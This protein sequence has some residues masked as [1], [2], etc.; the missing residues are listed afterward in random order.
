MLLKGKLTAESPIYRGNA[1]KTLF[2]RDGDGSQRMVSLSGEISGTA[3]ALM[4][5]F[6]GKSRNGKNIGLINSL[7]QRLYRS[8]M[9]DNLIRR[10]DCK[11]DKTSY[12]KD[13]F[14]D[15]RMGI[16]LDEERASAEANANY[17]METIFRHAVFDFSMDVNDSM[18]RKGELLP[19]LY[20]V[21]EELKSGRFWFGAGKS[22]GL[23]RCLLRLSNDLP[24]PLK[25]PK[26]DSQA[27]HMTI[28]IDINASNP[29]LIGWNWGKIDPNI[30]AFAAIEGK[31]LIEGLREIPE[32]IS[33]R[34][35]ISIGGPISSPDDWKEKFKQF[36]PKAIVAWLTDQGAKEKTFWIFPQANIAK[37]SKGKYP[38][39]KKL[40]N[41]VKKLG[42]IQ[43]SSKEDAEKA[44]ENA[45]GKD[46]KKAKRAL[47][48]LEKCSASTQDLDIDTWKQ[49][50]DPL[51][52]DENLVS[53]IAPLIKDDVALL[54]QLEKYLKVIFPQLFQKIDRQVKLIQSDAWVDME[55]STR[56]EHIMIKQMIGEGKI[57]EW[58][59]GDANTPP[60]GIK[61]VTWKE[62]MVSHSRV[63]YKHMTNRSNLAKSIQN[64]KNVI[65]FLNSYRNRTRQELSQSNLTDFRGGGPSGRFISQQFGKPYDTVF[66][67]M[68]TWKPSE[69]KEGWEV[70]I[71][72]STIK[73]AFRKRA[74]QILKTIWGDNSPKT[75]YV[76]ERIFG[77]QSKQGLI[78][79]SDAYLTDPNIPDKVW[80]SMDGVRMNPTTG[81]PVEEAKCD[82]LFAYGHQLLFNLR[83]D[84]MDIV[85]KDQEVLSILTYLLRDFQEGEI[86]IGGEKTNGFGWVNANVNTVQ[87][88]AA[89]SPQVVDKWLNLILPKELETDGPW[90][91]AVIKQDKLADA[92]TP[93]MPLQS[94][95]KTT[96]PP[97]AKEGFISHRSF[98]GHCGIL[99]FE[100]TALTPIAIKESGEPSFSQ[101]MDGEPV[102]GWDFFNMAS[103]SNNS[104]ESSKKYAIPSKTLK[105]MIRHIYT[106]ASDSVGTSP[107]IGSLNDVDSLF[108]WVGHGPNQALMGRVSFDFAFFKNPDLS[109]YKV[110]YPYGRW[111]YDNQKWKE[112][113]SKKTITPVKIKNWRIFTHA[114]IAPCVSQTDE[115]NP[116]TVQASYNRA[117]QAGSTCTFGVRFWNLETE[118]LQRLLWCFVLEKGLAH[119]CGNGRYLG[120]GSIQLKLLPES[121]TI[122]WDSRYSNDNWK[123]PVDLSKWLQKDCIKNYNALK[124]ALDAKCL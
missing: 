76:L 71:P 111:E 48:V 51:G 79:F 37:L 52:L 56:E 73:G 106:I 65:A 63:R 109:W 15:L 46:A 123:V 32:P 16:R 41:K 20:Y 117:V 42:D 6:I 22:K 107:N 116:D 36:F 34:L 95:I 122:K 75:R 12:P 14:F 62:F 9:P 103:P 18:I 10:V 57:T 3:Q 87:W 72:G 59:W 35:S 67:R 83:I 44:F 100:A 115:F 121:Y 24:K 90:K 60:K 118:E 1:K 40:L 70:Y 81:K 43:Y 98:G 112:T 26:I 94:E 27:N 31:L 54:K 124:D 68:L 120:L 93:I 47:N 66:M 104:R 19:Q 97:L 61:S 105:G 38:L 11:L 33:K 28:G 86:S 58:D 110:P 84:I 55:I 5:A 85:E 91:K 92:L 29:L 30:P 8:E 17:K 45:L 102:N 25:I 96:T 78:L 74:S 13:N 113:K 88:Q 50:A 99:F 53:E 21:L 69:N 108:G 4:D 7:W 80:C 2:T 82:Y 119:K 114:P 77:A 39:Q 101:Q 23:G 64:D 89:Q 49:I